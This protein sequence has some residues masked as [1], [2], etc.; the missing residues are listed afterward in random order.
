MILPSPALEKQADEILLKIRRR[1]GKSVEI[2]KLERSLRLDHSTVNAAL[3]LLTSYGYRLKLSKDAVIFLGAP[4][5]LSAT[6]IT[7]KLKTRWL[8]Q[9]VSAFNSVKSTNDLTTQMAERGA[10]NGTIVTAEQQTKGRGRFSRSWYSPPSAG[11]YLSILLRPRFKPEKAPG[12]S[13]MSA[14]ALADA[15]SHFAPGMVKIKWPNDLL[16]GGKK[17]A[18]FLTE[19]SA[20]RDKI[21]HVVVGIGI[22]VNHGVGSFPEEIRAT[23][24]SIRRAIRKKVNRVELLQRFLV[25][26]EKEYEIYSRHGLRK[27]LSRV[28]R[29]SSLIGSHVKIKSGR[30]ITEGMAVD[31]APDGSLILECDGA[32]KIISAGEVT[33]VKE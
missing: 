20:E 22:N 32:R 17:T 5:T 33:V 26:F 27:S 2:S 10:P 18:G 25:C 21:N 13:I 23:A 11:I 3:E 30:N 9:N 15:V 28:R 12:M 6:E 8:G 24:T 1:P 4:D 31:I 14:L 7:Y 29:Y 16:I 19:L